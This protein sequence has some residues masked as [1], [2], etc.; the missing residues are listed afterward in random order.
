MPDTRPFS[1][2]Y[3]DM[4]PLERAAFKGKVMKA[5]LVTESAIRNWANGHRVPSPVHQANIV[6]ALKY[7]KIETSPEILFPTTKIS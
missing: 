6:K 7:F 3:Q 1:A 4:S 2:V 5:S